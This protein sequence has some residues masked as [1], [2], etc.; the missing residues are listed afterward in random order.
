MEGVER[1]KGGQREVERQKG[2]QGE[3]EAESKVET[4][5]MFVCVRERKNLA[6]RED[7]GKGDRWS[8]ENESNS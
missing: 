1:D 5:S 8:K 6:K 7:G 4:R 2:K 3:T